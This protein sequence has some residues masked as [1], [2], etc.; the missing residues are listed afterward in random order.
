MGWLKK[1]I[2]QVGKGIKKIAKGIGKA[3][4]K[5]FKGIGAYSAIV[6]STVKATSALNGL[7][8]LIA[9]HKV[10]YIQ[11]EMKIIFSIT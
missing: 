8:G 6:F 5:V 7:R 11:I 1:K 10:S 9:Q 3:F 2:K 4:K